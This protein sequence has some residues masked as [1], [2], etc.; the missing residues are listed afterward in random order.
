MR[1]REKS[2]QI[3]EQVLI[4]TPD[5]NSSKLFSRWTGSAVIENKLSAD[6]YL[7]DMNDAVEH[8]HADK[9]RK[10]HITV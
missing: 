4:L 1:A 3:G 9:L 10:Y 2:F 5:S 8:F 7:V 6:N